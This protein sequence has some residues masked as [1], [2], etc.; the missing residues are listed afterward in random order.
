M[1]GRVMYEAM[2]KYENENDMPLIEWLHSVIPENEWQ[3]FTIDD[4][5][6]DY[7][8]DEDRF[9]VHQGCGDAAIESGN[10]ELFKWVCEHDPEEK[11]WQ[12]GRA[13]SAAAVMGERC[14]PMLKYLKEEKGCAWHFTRSEGSHL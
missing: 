11:S 13:L 7:P 3:S 9:W 1:T 8:G 4:E 12:R 14:I 5:N 10:V 2:R 6:Q